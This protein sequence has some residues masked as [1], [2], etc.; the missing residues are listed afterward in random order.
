MISNL[1]S[2]L[3]PKGGKQKRETLPERP[4]LWNENVISL[5][6]CRFSII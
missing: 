1:V 5:T 6:K 3:I 2:V 4:S